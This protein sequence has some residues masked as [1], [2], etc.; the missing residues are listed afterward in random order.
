MEDMDWF[1]VLMFYG[2]EN[3]TDPDPSDQDLELIPQLVEKVVVPKLTGQGRVCVCVC[4]WLNVMTLPPLPLASPP[5]S[6]TAGCVGPTILLADAEGSAADPMPCGR[7]PNRLLS[8]PSHTGPETH[9]HTHTNL[10][11]LL[12]FVSTEHVFCNP[13]AT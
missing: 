3:G 1:R 7:L 13:A 4:A 11:T 10:L 9:M 6:L 2:Y 5:N 8:K 12:P